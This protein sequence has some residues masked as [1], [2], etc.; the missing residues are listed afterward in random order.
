MLVDV[1]GRAVLYHMTCVEDIDI[2]GVDDLADVVA[3]DDDCA[4]LLDG[5][6]G[7]FYLLGGDG[8]EACGGFV[9]E[10]DGRVFEEHASDGDALLLS[11]AELESL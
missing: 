5:I 6:D 3:Y 4:I 10:D 7:G 2:V 1:V 11:A 8:I 9:E